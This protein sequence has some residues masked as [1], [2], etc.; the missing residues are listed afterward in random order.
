M[1][2]NLKNLPDL[3][4]PKEMDSWV[5]QIKF[6]PKKHFHKLRTKYPNEDN[7]KIILE[8][9]KRDTYHQQMFGKNI[10][11]RLDLSQTDKLDLIRYLLENYPNYTLGRLCEEFKIPKKELLELTRQM[12]ETKY[13]YFKCPI[14]LKITSREQ[15]ENKGEEEIMF[16]CSCEF[17]RNMGKFVELKSLG[18]EEYFNE[19]I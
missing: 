16:K 6:N 1:P 2:L 12:N 8:I 9:T 3:E 13:H 5:Q 18:F 4:N 17:R 11:Q 7:S 19:K 14:C 15:E 10:Y